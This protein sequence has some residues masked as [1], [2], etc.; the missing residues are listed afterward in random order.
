[1]KKLKFSAMLL[2]LLHAMSCS[3]SI[4]Q[5]TPET[6]VKSMLRAITEGNNIE[7]I[8]CTDLSYL[9]SDIPEVAEIE[10]AAFLAISNSL[11]SSTPYQ[12]MAPKYINDSVALVIARWRCKYALDND[13]FPLEGF[14]F[15]VVNH[16]NKWY[17]RNESIYNMKFD[18]LYTPHGIGGFDFGV[19]Y[20]NIQEG[21]VNLYDKIKVDEYFDEM[22][23]V[24]YKRYTFYLKKEAIF[25]VVTNKNTFDENNGINALT[26]LSPK[27]ET[28][29]NI[30]LKD[31]ATKLIG[32]KNVKYIPEFWTFIIDD[33]A[34]TVEGLSNSL[35]SR[36]YS[37]PADDKGV[38]NLELINS[39]FNRNAKIKSISIAS[40]YYRY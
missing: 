12:F 2:M 11:A 39:D 7:V 4:D 31:R 3:H 29:I 16:E 33:Y 32:M 22:D 1:M 13:N 23:D 6:C 10:K 14:A 17:V 40:D 20:S 21:I 15:E 34:I 28:T 37:I 36:S 24:H 8:Q 26:I 35:V 27:V 19:K 5:K 25:R 18:K 9:S 38:V 30:S